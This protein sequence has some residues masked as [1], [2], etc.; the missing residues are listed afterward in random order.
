MITL[1]M[2]TSTRVITRRVLCRPTYGRL[3]RRRATAAAAKPRPSSLR[4]FYYGRARI[5]TRRQ[6]HR[7]AVVKFRVGF[8][9]PRGPSW[10]ERSHTH[11]RARAAVVAG[12]GVFYL[13]YSAVLRTYDLSWRGR[14]AVICGFREFATPQII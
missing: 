7:P 5:R 14:A 8:F 12:D 1:F 10:T 13:I 6:R 11:T 4:F 2:F 3:A 9:F